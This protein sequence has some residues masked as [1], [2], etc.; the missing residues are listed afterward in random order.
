MKGKVSSILITQKVEEN[1]TGNRRTGTKQ[2]GEEG[3]SVLG[4]G[5]DA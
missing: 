2:C 1:S 4:N 3:R 5:T